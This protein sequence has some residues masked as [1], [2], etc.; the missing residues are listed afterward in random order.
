MHPILRLVTLALL[1]PALA[2][3]VERPTNPNQTY[4]NTISPFVMTLLAPILALPAAVA[5]GEVP[6]LTTEAFD[7]PLDQTERLTTKPLA[8]GKTYRITVFSASRNLAILRDRAFIFSDGVRFFSPSSSYP[9][10][11][12]G[13]VSTLEFFLDGK[14]YRLSVRSLWPW[15]VAPCVN[16]CPQKILKVRFTIVEVLPQ[17]P[18]P[19]RNALTTS[20]DPPAPGRHQNTSGKSLATSPLTPVLL[21]G[22]VA[23][24]GI[25]G[26]P[27]YWRVAA[28]MRS[29]QHRVFLRR[30]LADI[31]RLEQAR[32][33]LH[34]L[35]KEM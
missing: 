5:H 27:L 29:H 26:V 6:Y 16:D 4:Q 22:C 9:A 19:P 20:P 2:G 18:P 31:G 12:R 25:L 8:P 14:G 24:C 3:S 28:Y 32:N 21:L 11:S 7:L 15:Y 17:P 33:T 10:D 34:Q 35:R 23:A 30:L 1:T 13:V